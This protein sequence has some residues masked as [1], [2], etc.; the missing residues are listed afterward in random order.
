MR[1]QRKSALLKT[2]PLFHSDRLKCFAHKHKTEQT[3][4]VSQHLPNVGKLWYGQL[5]FSEEV[6]C[7]GPWKKVRVLNRFQ[8]YLYCSK[9]VQKSRT[10]TQNESPQ[11]WL[12]AL[13]LVCVILQLFLCDHPG[14]TVRTVCYDLLVQPL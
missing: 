1:G 7:N 13:E 6:L 5:G 12:Q 3:D 10:L 9:Q 4:T 8:G 2:R 11:V 14:V